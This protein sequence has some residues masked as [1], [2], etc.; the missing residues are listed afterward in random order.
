[1]YT[2]F[3]LCLTVPLVHGVCDYASSWFNEHQPW[4]I[5]S[6]GSDIERYSVIGAKYPWVFEMTR[7]TGTF[8]IRRAPHQALTN[9][10]LLITN[11]TVIKDGFIC[12][13][14]NGKQ[15]VDYEVRLSLA[16][17]LVDIFPRPDSFLSGTQPLQRHG[18][19][20]RGESDR[21]RQ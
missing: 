18:F 20:S 12:H 1:M 8:E 15:C 13:A 3:I 19:P 2:L 16:I 21:W 7:W 5:E 4:D 9:E 14:V 11:Y 10:S 6:M 17:E